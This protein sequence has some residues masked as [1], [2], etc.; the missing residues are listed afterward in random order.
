M[1]HNTFIFNVFVIDMHSDLAS[2]RNDRLDG[3][4]NA[5]DVELQVV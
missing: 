3:A 1:Q 2:V 5:S 4:Y